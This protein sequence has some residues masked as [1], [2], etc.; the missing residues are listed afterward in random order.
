MFR[1]VQETDSPAAAVMTSY[2]KRAIRGFAGFGSVRDAQKYI[3]I[4]RDKSIKR[5]RIVAGSVWWSSSG[6]VNR[7]GS[8]GRGAVRTR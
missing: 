5:I 7:F 2:K 8:E 1:H 6:G 3:I 4:V